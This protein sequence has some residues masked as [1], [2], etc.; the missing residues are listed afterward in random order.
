[1]DDAEWLATLLAGLMPKEPEAA[2]LLALIR[3]HRARGAARFDAGK[4]LVLL[5]NQDRTLWDRCHAEAER[6]EDTDWS[7]IVML[8]DMLLHLTPSP[9]T[10]LHRAIAV[11]YA[12]GTEEALTELKTLGD[13]LER[14]PLF[15][16]TL[17]E[18]LRERARRDEARRADER[19]LELTANPAQQ[20]LLE[21]RIMWR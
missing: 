15:H 18:L 12:Q 4:R 19:A 14:Y 8:Y 11:R 21:E 16:A 7:Q 6:F 1:M 17:A 3:L 13:T 10:R 5:A 20:A 9:V 2:G